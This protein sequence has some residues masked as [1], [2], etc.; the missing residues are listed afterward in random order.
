MSFF[1]SL[2][3]GGSNIPEIWYKS[4]WRYNHWRIFGG[5]PKRQCHRRINSDVWQG[6]LM[7]STSLRR[8]INLRQSISIW[9][10]HFDWDCLCTTSLSTTRDI[11]FKKILLVKI[12]TIKKQNHFKA[13]VLQKDK[14]QILVYI[15]S[16]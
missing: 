11:S 16:K 8:N 6:Y 2:F 12:Q 3:P 10:Y 5:L 13:F 4:R 15:R 1:F 9:N 7:N 14:K